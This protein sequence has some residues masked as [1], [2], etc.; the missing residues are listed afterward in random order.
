MSGSMIGSMACSAKSVHD[1]GTNSLLGKGFGIDHVRFTDIKPPK[2]S[3]KVGR[4]LFQVPCGTQ[5]L[6][7]GA[8][9]DD[10]LRGW[11]EGQIA[12]LILEIVNKLLDVRINDLKPLLWGV[13]PG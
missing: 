9:F 12:A 7:E 5:D 6:H 4:S 8:P 1:R 13:M 2:G 3:V 11:G 10:F